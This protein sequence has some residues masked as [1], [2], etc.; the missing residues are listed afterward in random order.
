MHMRSAHPALLWA[1]G[2]CLL[3]SG[4][5]SAAVD[6]ALKL[7]TS[8]GRNSNPFRFPDLALPAEGSDTSA[9]T[10]LPAPTPSA[11]K[12]HGLEAGVSIPLGSQD[13]RLVLTTQ[14]SRQNL[15]DLPQISHTASE[16]NVQL[17][18]R[19]GQLW[20]GSLSHRQQR[21]PY[22]YEDG[23]YTRLDMVRRETTAAQLALKIT[24]S[25]E[26]PLNVQR[27]MVRHEDLVRHGLLDLDGVLA[28]LATRYRATNDSIIEVGIQRSRSH[29]VSRTA[30]QIAGLD[31]RYTDMD[32]YLDV[33]WQYSIKSRVGARLALRQRR[34]ATLAERNSSMTDLVLRA[35]HF[36]S[37]KTRIDIDLFNQP[38]E[39]NAFNSLYAQSR[40]L[41][42]Q[43]RWKHSPKTQI[44]F[45]GL[46]ERNVDVPSPQG[47]D[48][49]AGQIRT[50]RVGARVQH[51]ITRG[52]NLFLDATHEQQRRS[53]IPTPIRQNLIRLGLDYTYENSTGARLKAGV[54]GPP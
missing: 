42:A 12:Q 45:V 41:R 14:L 22:P 16:H 48:Q 34:H 39:T 19:L 52:L 44:I 18:W 32:R 30:E 3:H 23:S 13:T 26:V 46:H 36:H 38:K 7:E 25:L 51:E 40:G 37:P 53:G 20:E 28:G 33:S 21:T 35:T 49:P 2:C 17:P 50:T 10:P 27:Q 11:L 8:M 5:A 9:A 6:L 29:Y 43:V 31:E 15:T 47:L 54:G 1:I 4:T 24:P